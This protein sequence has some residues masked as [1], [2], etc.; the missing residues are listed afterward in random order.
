MQSVNCCPVFNSLVL[1]PIM[2]VTL[3]ILS[4]DIF[5]HSITFS[6]L[7]PP[8]S[9]SLPLLPSLP[10]LLLT[11]SLPHSLSSPHS[12]HS[13]TPPLP[14]LPSLPSLLHSPTPSPP[15]TPLT[16]SPSL[17]HSLSSPL[18]SR[19]YHNWT[20]FSHLVPKTIK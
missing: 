1:Q 3:P 14:L 12:P 16:P 20:N 9:P 8:Q 19:Y 15:L 11:P 6:P 10:S 13:F 7:P 17:P 2:A 18:S 4:L 5:Y